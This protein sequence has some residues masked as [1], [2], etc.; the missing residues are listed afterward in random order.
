MP[1]SK[2]TA[3]QDRGRKRVIEEEKAKVDSEEGQRR[4]GKH[5]LF[6]EHLHGNKLQQFIRCILS[7]KNSPLVSERTQPQP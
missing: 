1:E 7:K 6:I 4:E 5:L 3:G 2:Q